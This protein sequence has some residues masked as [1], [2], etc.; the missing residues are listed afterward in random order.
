[1][2][3]AYRQI[4]VG[5]NLLVAEFVRGLVRWEDEPPDGIRHGGDA[6]PGFDLDGLERDEIGDVGTR[7]FLIGG[8]VPV[9]LL[10]GPVPSRVHARSRRRGGHPPA[11]QAESDR[12]WR[13]AW[14]RRVAARTATRRTDARSERGAFHGRSR[15]PFSGRWCPTVRAASHGCLD[16][17]C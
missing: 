14:F 12:E 9:G 3:S 7:P 4:I 17:G 10:D 13:R 6:G 8:M 15:S 16:G 1:M 11:R 5:S 2:G